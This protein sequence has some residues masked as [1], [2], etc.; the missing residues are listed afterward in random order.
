ML[1]AASAVSFGFLPIFARFAYGGG[2]GVQ[3][4]LLIRFA[5]AFPLMAIFLA[6]T[7]RVLIPSR[8]QLLALLVLGG[9]GYFLQSTLYFTA[10][11]YIPVSIVALI[12]YTYPAFV[13]A[14][15]IA[16]R[17]ERLS[18]PVILSLLLAL[19]GL[20]LITNPMFNVGHMATAGILIAFGAA[21][22][23][24]LYILLSTRILKGL[25][26]EI[27]SFYVMGFAGLS[28]GLSGLLTGRLH[29]A[30]SLEAWIWAI[31]IASIS[32]TLAITAFFKGLKLIGPSRAS[33]LS[34]IEPITSII[35]ASILFNEYLNTIQWLGG[36]LIL[37]ATILATSQPTS[38]K[39]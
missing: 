32:T 16:L 13:T 1:V 39:K 31:L 19:T 14:G 33:I 10:L 24:T 29:I 23:Y 28:F 15:S 35:A 8:G 18:P 37:L 2:A 7:G 12:L 21:V 38:R 20:I 11:L 34:I 9:G 17:W 6:L 25:A 36:L 22:T 26:G 30:W 27:A 5:L 4:L 3:D